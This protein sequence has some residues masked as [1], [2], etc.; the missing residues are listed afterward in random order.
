MDSILKNVRA[1]RQY[2]ASDIVQIY[3]RSYD[4]VDAPTRKS[5]DKLLH[6]WKTYPSGPLFAPDILQKI[7]RF[8]G[9]V[10]QHEKTLE[11]TAVPMPVSW[12]S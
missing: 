4:A 5:L 3:C 6:T 1:Y 12:F 2:F 9:Q 7:D 8:V 10:R 11:G